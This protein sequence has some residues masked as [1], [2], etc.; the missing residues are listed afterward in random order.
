MEKLISSVYCNSRLLMFSC[1]LCTG[2]NYGG[3]VSDGK[4]RAFLLSSFHYSHGFFVRFINPQKEKSIFRNL[5]SIYFGI[6]RKFCFEQQFSLC[7]PMEKRSRCKRYAGSDNR[8]KYRC[9]RRKN[10]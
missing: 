2:S 8:I 3:N 1:K 9:H 5:Y 7:Y 4:N 10:T 6:Y